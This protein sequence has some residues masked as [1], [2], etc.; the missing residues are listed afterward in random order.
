[1]KRGLKIVG[2]VVAVLLLL[3]A[4]VALFIQTRGIPH[5]DVPALTPRTVASTP[6]RVELG[7]KLVL[8]TCADCHLNRETQSLSG[9][10]LLDIPPEFGRVYAANITQDPNHGIGRWTD[11][12]LV[13]LLRTGIGPDGRYRVVMPSFALMSDE[14]VNSVIAFLRSDNALVKPNATPSKEQEPS[15]LLKALTNSVM[16]PTPMPATEV[17]AP[18]AENAVAYGR[19]LVVGRYKCYDCH[20]KDF[21]TNNPMEPEK[22]EG[23]LGGGNRM[24]NLE[25]QEVVTR[26]IT[27]DPETG[28][29]NWTEEQFA[30]SV[31][32]GMSPKGPL[33]YP[34]PKYSTLSDDEVHAIFA[35]L[36]SVP[37]IKNATPEDGGA[38]ASR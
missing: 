16:K 10:E 19:Y 30:R 25:K 2:V 26:N 36:Q 12:Q 33:A 20:S 4:G 21:K 8:S 7:E 6:S 37:K 11:A 3:A 35:Y 28:I 13:T 31:K 27:G 5:Y 23:Y 24:L 32:F 22:S 9:H 34:M 17:K 1:M 38:L 14:D 18:T 15:F 29:G